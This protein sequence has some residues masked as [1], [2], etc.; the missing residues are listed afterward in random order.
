M[1]GGMPVRSVVLVISVD[2]S[3]AGPACI[4]PRDGS[5]GLENLL[6]NGV[7]VVWQ[8]GFGVGQC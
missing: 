7:E 8:P 4:E 1:D 5:W 2:V 6:E 3:V